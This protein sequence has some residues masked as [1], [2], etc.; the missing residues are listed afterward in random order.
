MS[1]QKDYWKGYL[2]A[3]NDY[4]PDHAQKRISILK[5]CYY[6]SGDDA[7]RCSAA[8]KLGATYYWGMAVRPDPIEGKKYLKYAAELNEGDA[9]KYY[10]M[11][12]L[13]DGDISGADYLLQSLCLNYGVAAQSAE[14]LYLARQWYLKKGREDKA[15]YIDE[16]IARL[17]D[18]KKQ[19]PEERAGG[20]EVAKAIAIQY[21]LADR[22]EETS[23]PARAYLQQADAMDN[24]YAT[25]WI[26]NFPQ[27]SPDTAALE[28]MLQNDDA[29]DLFLKF[30]SPKEDLMSLPMPPWLQNNSAQTSAGSSSGGSGKSADS[31]DGFLKKWGSTLIISAVA[32]LILQSLTYVPFIL[33]FIVITAV[34][35]LIR[36]WRK[37]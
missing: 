26:N 10:G 30:P 36:K 15:A 22:M 12:L 13:R 28:K 23:E 6:N 33:S 11:I 19:V 29:P 20:R 34:L 9:V 35:A 27:Y 8:Y 24:G 3:E 37:N 2:E 21:H 4:S 1:E 7:L 32:S 14:G 5:D 25:F 17:W 16:L 18:P 31:Q